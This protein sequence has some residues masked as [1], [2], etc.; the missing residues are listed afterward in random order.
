[1]NKAVYEAQL[2][3]LIAHSERVMTILRA[4]RQK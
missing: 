4:I 2:R 3:Q 1:M